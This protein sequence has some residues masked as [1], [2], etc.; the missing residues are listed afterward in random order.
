MIV[1]QPK[2]YI[3]ERF[4]WQYIHYSEREALRLYKSNFPQFKTKELL[5]TNI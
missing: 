4:I 2:N 1:I 5:I 3:S